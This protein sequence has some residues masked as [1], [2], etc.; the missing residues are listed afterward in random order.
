MSDTENFSMDV[1]PGEST[2]P[3]SIPKVKNTSLQ[4]SEKTFTGKPEIDNKYR[5]LFIRIDEM[6]AAL[7]EN[8]KQVKL[9]RHSGEPAQEKRDTECILKVKDVATRLLTVTHSEVFAY[10]Y[11]NFASFHNTGTAIGNIMRG[12]QI[13]HGSKDIRV[14]NMA[15]LNAACECL[16]D[17]LVR[18]KSF[19]LNLNA[20]NQEAGFPNSTFIEFLRS[21]VVK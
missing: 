7:N 8:A 21:R 9:G 19:L 6:F 18:G 2:N 17:T 10:Y 15:A 16:Y 5:A 4:S 11:R 1:N 12:I 14:K 3:T 13:Y 20:I